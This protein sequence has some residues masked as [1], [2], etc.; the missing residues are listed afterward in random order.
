MY[1]CLCFSLI[2]LDESKEE[3]ELDDVA[4]RLTKIAD[5]IPFIPPEIEADCPG[6]FSQHEP[7]IGT[8]SLCFA[9]G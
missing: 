7:N 9:F 4:G 1:V 3:D 6:D 2:L 8:C 5:E